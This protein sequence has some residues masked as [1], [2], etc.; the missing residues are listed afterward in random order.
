M[1]CG[2]ALPRPGAVGIV[3]SSV[4]R[5]VLRSGDVR[6]VFREPG[7]PRGDGERRGSAA[8]PSGRESTARPSG[9]EFS[10]VRAATTWLAR[11]LADPVDAQCLRRL[12][13]ELARGQPV[14]DDRDVLARVAGALVMRRVE[15]VR[16]G[17][18]RAPTRLAS[19]VDERKPAKFDFDAPGPL[20]EDNHWIE[21]QLL[22]GDDEP[23]V[24]ERCRLV[25]SDERVF[26][27]YT[28]ATGL[29]RWTRLP[30]GVCQITFLD[31]DDA[32]FE[33]IATPAS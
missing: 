22:D 24:G 11:F 4:N 9:L 32:S 23:V 27:G 20:V 33:K 31:L 7:Q 8:R 25:T 18:T 3:V 13:G 10:D 2:R 26:T 17:P 19:T 29:I 15:L 16:A 28:D 1:V 21:V 12:A 5:R 6:Y 30:P 14:H